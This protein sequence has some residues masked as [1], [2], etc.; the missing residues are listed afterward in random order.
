ML[1]YSQDTNNTLNVIV[2]FNF[3]LISGAEFYIGYGVS[4]TEMLSSGSFRGFY[5]VP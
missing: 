3:G 5:R 1:R 2:D 4:D